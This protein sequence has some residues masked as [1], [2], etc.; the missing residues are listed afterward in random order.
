MHRREI[1]GP[2]GEEDFSRCRQF[3]W[4][5][6]KRKEGPCRRVNKFRT[7]KIQI[8]ILILEANLFCEVADPQEL[9]SCYALRSHLLLDAL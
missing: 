1:L 6:V 7:H 2:V 8:F 9:C 5:F 3:G 4:Q